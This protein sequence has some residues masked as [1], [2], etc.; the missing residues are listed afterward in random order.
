MGSSDLVFTHARHDNPGSGVIA[1]GTVTG[2]TLTDTPDGEPLGVETVER[3]HWEVGHAE[4]SGMA[5]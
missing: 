4:P 1:C 3:V 5:Q 2:H